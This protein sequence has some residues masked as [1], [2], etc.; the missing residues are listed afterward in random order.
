[1]CAYNSINGQPACANEFL[2]L[3]PSPDA[4]ATARNADGVVAV[5]GITSELEGEDMQV[6]EDGFKGGDRKSLDLPKPE[7]DLL[8]A[9]A[10]TG[11]PLVV[12]LRRNL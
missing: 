12:V 9:L 7:K 6:N 4:V 10:A 8:K 2:H 11:K 1:M 5:V 3:T